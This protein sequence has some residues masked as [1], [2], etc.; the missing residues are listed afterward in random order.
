[1]VI[2]CLLPFRIQSFPCRFAV[3]RIAAGVRAEVGLGQ[4]E[5]ADRLAGRHPGDPAVLLLLRAEGVDR[6]H[7]ERALDGDEAAEP[8][9]AAFQ[10]L[11]DETVGDAAQAGQAVLVE[12][13]REEV[14]GA[15]SGTRASGVR[16][17]R[18]HSSMIG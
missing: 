18:W 16:P 3:V 13:G 2:H 11:H 7:D 12:T 4:A 9:V 14:Q 5:T 8:G 17:S 1:L 6:I 15:I 10:L